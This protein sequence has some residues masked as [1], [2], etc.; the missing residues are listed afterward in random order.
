MAHIRL[1]SKQK[2]FSTCIGLSCKPGHSK[3]RFQSCFSK[4]QAGYT[5]PYRRAVLEAMSGSS[6]HEP[7]ILGARMPVYDEVAIG[8]VLILTYP[9]LEQWR[10][11]ERWKAEF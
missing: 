9:R 2:I 5:F 6:A 8:T 7:Y 1:K 10:S 4:H 11:L 3:E